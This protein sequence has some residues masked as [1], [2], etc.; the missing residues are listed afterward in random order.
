MGTKKQE[1]E[2]W[3][4]LQE[5]EDN[6]GIEVTYPNGETKLLFGQDKEELYKVVDSDF[7]SAYIDNNT[8]VFIDKIYLKL[9]NKNDLILEII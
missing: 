9:K 8:E 3:T 4:V 6:E 7:V 2:K 5:I 1:I